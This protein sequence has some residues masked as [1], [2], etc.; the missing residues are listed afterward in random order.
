M[1]KR[2]SE[3]FSG[4]AVI[5]V[6][7]RYRNAFLRMIFAEKI[8]ASVREKGQNEGLIA[9]ISPKFVK[10]IPFPHI[11]LPTGAKFSKL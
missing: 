9:E 1:K 5:S 11:H 2:F 4:K 8:P 7:E 6:E 10:K 3:F